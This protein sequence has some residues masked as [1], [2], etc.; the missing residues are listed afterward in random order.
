[1]FWSAALRPMPLALLSM[2]FAFL[3]GDGGESSSAGGHGFDWVGRFASDAPCFA[4]H[5]FC[6]FI[7]DGGESGLCGV[8][9]FDWVGRFA[10]EAPCFASGGAS[11]R[12]GRGLSLAGWACGGASLS[13]TFA[14]LIGDGGESSS[15]GGHGFD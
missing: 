7:G 4:Q 1:M 8:H 14:F 3:I 2:T 9:A 10:S 5:D 11:L 15:A 13:M 6:F 12:A